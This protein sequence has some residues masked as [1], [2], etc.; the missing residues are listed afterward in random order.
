MAFLPRPVTMMMLVRPA[1]TASSITYWMMGLSTRGSI[2]LGW[3][4]VAGRKRVPRPAAGNTALR[5]QGFI[6]CGPSSGDA[7]TGAPSACGRLAG[8]VLDLRW[9]VENPEAVKAML[10]DRGQTLDPAAGDP[11]A[12]DRD[13]RSLLQRVEQLRHRQRLA[14]EEIARRGRQG[15]DA[16]GLK[17]EMKG[18]AEEIKG[19]E[20][21]LAEVEEALR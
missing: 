12:L 20:A 8:C 4:L 15:E 11:W 13:R 7:S 21:R 18:V 6:G 17:A 16:A 14:G 3:A 1:A 2:S 19:L 9:V 10:A 5:T